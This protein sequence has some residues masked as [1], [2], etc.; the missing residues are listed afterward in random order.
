MD[1]G[2]GNKIYWWIERFKTKEPSLKD[3]P[4]R[5]RSNLTVNDENI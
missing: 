3:K 5:G 1:Y 2:D 4:R